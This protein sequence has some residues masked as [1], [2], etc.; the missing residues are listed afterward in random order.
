[1][2]FAQRPPLPRPPAQPP[3]VL[4]C[5]EASLHELLAAATAL[6]QISA[7][8]IG[9]ASPGGAQPDTD[10]AVNR[11]HRGYDNLQQALVDAARAPSAA[12]AL[13]ARALSP[14]HR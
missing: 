13:T 14:A 8:T 6:E 1:V 9:A 4:G 7:Q 12:R 2:P 11:M 3:A 5:L 10:D